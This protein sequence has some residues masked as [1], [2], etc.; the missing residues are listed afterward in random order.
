M[1]Q[2]KNLVLEV[3]YSISHRIRELLQRIWD[4]IRVYPVG[5]HPWHDPATVSCVLWILYSSLA[6]FRQLRWKEKK[7]KCLVGKCNTFY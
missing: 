2:A 7:L 3:M 1:S 5:L 6:S 4:E